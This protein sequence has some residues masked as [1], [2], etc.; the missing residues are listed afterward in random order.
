M[1]RSGIDRELTGTECA[2]HANDP[3]IIPHLRT[4]GFRKLRE[5]VSVMFDRTATALPRLFAMFNQ[6]FAF[7]ME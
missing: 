4:V 3:V 1:D 5:N 2:I 7:F 6:H